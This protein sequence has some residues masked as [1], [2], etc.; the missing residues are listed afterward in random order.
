VCSAGQ[1]AGLM[2]IL[3]LLIC[4]LL[5]GYLLFYVFELT[6]CW[7]HSNVLLMSRGRILFYMAFL[8]FYFFID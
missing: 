6:G 7:R 8:L 2:I 5:D 3:N 4:N 1:E